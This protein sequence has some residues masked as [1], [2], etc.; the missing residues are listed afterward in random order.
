MVDAKSPRVCVKVDQITINPGDVITLLVAGSDSVKVQ[1]EVR[2]VGMPGAN[3]GRPEL[4]I[5]DNLDLR[6]RSF[7]EWMPMDQAVRHYAGLPR[8]PLP[9]GNSEDGTA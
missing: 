4:F 5:D 7:K 9:A 1:I 3:V 6:I 2:S 8:E